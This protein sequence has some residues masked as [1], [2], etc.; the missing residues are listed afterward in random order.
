MDTCTPV[1]LGAVVDPRRDARKIALV[2]VGSQGR[3]RTFSFADLDA[4]ANAAARGLLRAGLRR[5]D[6]VAILS[7][8]SA[9]FLAVHNGAMRAGLVSVPVNFKLPAAVVA[10][11][12]RDCDARLVLLDRAHAHLVPAG[13]RAV[14]LDGEGEGSLAGLM[15]PGAFEP[16]VP[17]PGETAMLLYTSGSTGKPKGVVLSH[18]SHVWVSTTIAAGVGD[19]HRLL[20]SAPMYHMNALM[21][22]AI[23]PA[24]HATLVLLPQFDAAAYVTAA[25]EHRC[26]WLTSVPTMFALILREQ[27]ALARADFSSVEFVSMASAP[28]TQ[29]LYDQVRALFPQANVR[30]LYGTTEA[31][32]VV[33]GPHPQGLPQPDLSTGCA[34]PH[35][36]LRLVDAQGREADEGVLQIRCPGLMTG[37]LNLPDATR[38]AITPDGFSVT[39]DVFRRDA[40]GFFFFVGRADDM[41]VCGGENVYPAE[42]EQLLE[43]HPDVLQACVVAVP[44]EVKGAKPVAFVV[45]RAGARPSESDVRGFCLQHGPAYQH[46]R[47][48]TFLPALPLAGT[49]KIDRQALLQA[50]LAAGP[51]PS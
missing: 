50:A 34:S 51:L 42:V 8:N 12:L 44:D 5:G 48:V 43:R 35:V 40:N 33:F 9:E 41:F 18:Q 7:F 13:A 36:Q 37:Y 20:V 1:N 15:D 11:V 16:V 32:P 2:D 6:R 27:E 17:Q 22:C 38:K 23:A 49:N 46:P 14:C 3:P 4:M 31:G 21:M 24:A 29:A 39:G 30:N 25:S 19:H 26:T 45:P 10:Y 47:R 28:L